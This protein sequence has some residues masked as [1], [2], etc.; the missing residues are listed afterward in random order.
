M[1]SLN[2]YILMYSGF[3]DSGP[4]APRG[5]HE[6]VET[7]RGRDVTFVHVSREVCERESRVTRL[8]SRTSDLSPQTHP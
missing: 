5:A 6:R 7:L 1:R 4:R 8:E 2:T 3:I